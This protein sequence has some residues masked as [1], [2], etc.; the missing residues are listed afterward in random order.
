MISKTRNHEMVQAVA[1]D[2]DLHRVTQDWFDRASR[3]STRTTSSGLGDRSSSIRRMS[4]PS[5]S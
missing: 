2:D 5:R 1:Q 3:T 4:W